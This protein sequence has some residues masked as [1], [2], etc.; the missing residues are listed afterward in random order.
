M[1]AICAIVDV[2]SDQTLSNVIFSSSKSNQ[3]STGKIGQESRQDIHLDAQFDS[4]KKRKLEAGN[5]QV[6]SIV[7]VRDS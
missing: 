3:D 5:A 4:S 6:T 1:Q 7:T 2:L